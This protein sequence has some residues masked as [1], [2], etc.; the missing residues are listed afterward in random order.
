VANNYW[1]STITHIIW[2]GDIPKSWELMCDPIRAVAC[3]RT[4]LEVPQPELPAAWIIDADIVFNTFFDARLSTAEADCTA[5]I[6]YDVRAL[7]LHEFGHFGGLH[8][9]AT[10]PLAVM[11]PKYTTCKR[12]L[13]THDISSMGAKYPIL[14]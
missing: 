14:L 1:Q 13:T 6:P 10:D 2:R 8:H 11:F 5:N 3:T 9:A 7:A 12:T 4:L